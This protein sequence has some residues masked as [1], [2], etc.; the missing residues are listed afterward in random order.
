[1]QAVA[2]Y[3]IRSIVINC[4][5]PDMSNVIL[6][7]S[8]FHCACG[9]GNGDLLIPGIKMSVAAKLGISPN[10]VY[11]YLIMHHSHLA[12]FMT[13]GVAG[14][15]YFLKIMAADKDVT[16]KFDLD[17]L[18]M[19]GINKWLPGRHTH[20]ITASSTG[21]VSPLSPLKESLAISAA[22]C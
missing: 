19:E 5:Y 18:I 6:W 10:N 21:I 20:A 3:E 8:G 9:T 22:S 2:K 12:Q 7:R 11:P 14:S 15:P 16:P 17:K 13:N 4:C 1:M